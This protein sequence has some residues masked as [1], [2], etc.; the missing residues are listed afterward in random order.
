MSARSGAPGLAVRSLP[1]TMASCFVSR[2][3]CKS[4]IFQF[5]QMKP[6]KT[7]SLRNSRSLFLLLGLALAGLPGYLAARTPVTTK[8]FPRKTPA[9]AA[10]LFGR[11]VA[12]SEKWLLV[13]SPEDDN[14][15]PAATAP[16]SVYVH[17]AV[18]GRFLRRLVPADGVAGDEFGFSV[19]VCGNLALIGAPDAL[20]A[21]NGR[22]RAYLYNLVN[23]ALLRTFVAPDGIEQNNFATAVALSDR[24]AAVSSP[25]RTGTTFEGIYVYELAT[26]NL[27]A[28][29]MGNGIDPGEGFGEAMAMCGRH[30]LVG[31]PFGE[32]TKGE[33]ILFD[34]EKARSATPLPGTPGLGEVYATPL[35]ASDGVAG[36][37]FGIRVA[38]S[39]DRILVAAPFRSS[40]KGGVYIYDLPTGTPLGSVLP[41]GASDGDRFGS[42]VSISGNLGLIGASRMDSGRGGAYLLD[43]KGGL[44]VQQF[45]VDITQSFGLAVSICGNTAA[46]GAPGDDMLAADSGAAYLIRPLASELPMVTLTQRRDSAPG[47]VDVEFN[48]LGQP[49]INPDGEVTFLSSL[50]GDGSNRGRDMGIYTTTFSNNRLTKLIKTRDG[51]A[52]IGVGLNIGAVVGAVSSQANS[53]VMDLRVTGAGVNRTNNQVILGF[54]GTNLGSIR[55]GVDYGI[56]GNAKFAGF[57]ELVHAGPQGSDRIALPF[58]LQLDPA[59]AVDT[60]N[61]SGILIADAAGDPPLVRDIDAREGKPVA[62]SATDT[63]G[64]FLGRT[65]ARATGTTGNEIDFY[66]FSSYVRT[67]TTTGKSPGLMQCFSKQ[68]ATGTVPTSIARQG[69]AASFKTH[70]S[71]TVPM[72]FQA[73]LGESI[74]VNGFGLVRATLAG[75]ANQAAFNEGLWLE[76]V[77]PGPAEMVLHKSEEFV[78]SGATVK[79]GRILSFWP[80]GDRIV[81]LVKGYG[82]GINSANDCALLVAHKDGANWVLQS[83]L[84]EGDALC[85]WD[86]PRVAAIQRVEV[87]PVNGHYAI[88]AALTGSKGRN[89]ALLL[90][91]LDVGND[92]ARHSLR[93]P[94]MALRKGTLYNTRHSESTRLLSI[95]LRPRLDRSG[96]GGK[97]LGQ[98]MNP[99]GVLT[100]A[101]AFDNG[102][103]EL[104]VGRP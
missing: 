46:I 43:V 73:M 48:I 16:G 29:L 41:A 78:S 89:Q 35:R 50:T 100:A 28:K 51:A 104:M 19:A 56:F 34:I 44:F 64:E 85:D 4:W 62:G 76:P 21:G 39:G 72:T 82:V 47:D 55:T 54:N 60:T 91:R 14:T 66:V 88:V 52:A 92:T 67:A 33:A 38:M 86:C 10:D 32:G 11:S 95:D 18:T 53:V 71:V 57:S 24:Y 13:G 7:S 63:F 99:V 69:D 80:A 23:G 45:P 96:A 98:V 97:G 27:V 59:A 36:D 40:Q 84:R 61:D 81:V 1:F 9:A 49:G 101:L 26:G 103:V 5:C 17:D 102:A 22:G 37:F 75:P 74:N 8:L 2:S 3:D 94:V 93:L 30:V 20:P 68:S 87:D 65:A 90:G 12:V 58:R 15:G 42:S 31:V 70:P 83:L 77:T 6:M 79:V 25:S